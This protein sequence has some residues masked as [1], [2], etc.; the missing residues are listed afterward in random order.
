MINYIKQAQAE[1]NAWNIADEFKGMAL[2]DIQTIQRSRTL[3]YAVCAL[4]VCGDLNIGTMLRS[5][6]IMGAERFFIIG[7]RQYDRRSTV[8]AQNYIDLVRVDGMIDEQTVDSCTVLRT[9]QEYNY[10][11]VF[12]EQGGRDIRDYNFK[13]Y[14]DSKPCFV[15]GNEGS[16]IPTDLLLHGDT[17]SVRQVGVMRSLNVSSTCA[18]VLDRVVEKIGGR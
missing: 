6:V 11:P 3:P 18:I 13:K 1:S 12:V 8:G 15:F 10:T 16:G 2:E 9:L 17:I 5:S 14:D 4:N 7:R